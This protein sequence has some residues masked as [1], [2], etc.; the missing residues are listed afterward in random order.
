MNSFEEKTES[1]KH[2]ESPKP[3][4]IGIADKIGQGTYKTVYSCGITNEDKAIFELPKGTDE[5]KLCIA[6]VD[7]IKIIQE[8][9]KNNNKFIVLFNT[10]IAQT[11]EERL[12]N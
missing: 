11:A 5:T 7:I 6:I 10:Y 3:V 9:Y 4:F 2:P 1:P 8:K 12:A